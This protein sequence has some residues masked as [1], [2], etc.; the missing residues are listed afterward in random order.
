MSHISGGQ[1]P[2]SRTPGSGSSNVPPVGEK[3]FSSV[4]EEIDFIGTGNSVTQQF[5]NFAQSGLRDAYEASL[6][7]PV[8]LMP[9]IESSTAPRP[10]ESDYQ[11]AINKFFRDKIQEIVLKKIKHPERAHEVHVNLLIEAALS[12]EM[13]KL[14]EADRHV[15]EKAREKT[16]KAWSLPQNWKINSQIA[17]DWTPT[18]IHV[19][20]PI[21]LNP[22]R[23][24]IMVEN[25]E[26]FLEVFEKVAIK[27]INQLP[28]NDPDRIAGRDLIDILS[29]AIRSL[30]NMLM[31]MQVKDAKHAVKTSEMK[32][33]TVEF[34]KVVFEQR[35]K[36]WDNA[37]KIRS[38]QTN[39][40]KSS[41]LMG[42]GLAALMLVLTICTM[43]KFAVVMAG[44]ML[45]YSIVD[46]QLGLTAKLF[47]KLNA[48]L[49]ATYPNNEGARFGAKIGILIG[50]TIAFVAGVRCAPL[51]AGKLLLTVAQQAVVQFTAMLIMSSNFLGEMFTR[52]GAASGNKGFETFMTILGQAVT[53]I[54]LMYGVFKGMK[55]LE[56]DKIK[57][58][59]EK[60]AAKL[61]PV[62]D[63]LQVVNPVLK[64]TSHVIDAR[65]GI[66]NA[67]LGVELAKILE[68]QAGHEKTLEIY[69][70]LMKMWDQMLSNV[71]RGTKDTSQFLISLDQALA[72][73]YSY[74]SQ[75][76]KGSSR[77]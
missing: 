35:L 10:F 17:E 5:L 24:Q 77:A 61:L 48:H 27:T 30:M 47:E 49:E 66:T 43:G 63:T 72:S 23:T 14:S 42:P 19:I 67:I 74:S 31:D 37:M 26:E 69:E 55:P 20:P 7:L 22:I 4:R 34:R 18:T 39:E 13:E 41:Q 36:E 53:I 60:L 8:L 3:A 50:L 15:I 21:D 45:I 51:V 46:S 57:F 33:E 29:R 76:Y 62:S 54:A 6:H 38:E 71:H 59:G 73:L 40:S 11:R 32:A 56:A 64:V 28:Q 44:I 58:I 16:Q 52:L 68:K 65:A 70:A 9:D 25:V 75:A 12:G 1:E 2:V